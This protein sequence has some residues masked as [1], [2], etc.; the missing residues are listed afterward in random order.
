[1]SELKKCPKCKTY[2]LK[3]ECKK[4]NVQTKSTHYKFPQVR[5]APPRSVPFKR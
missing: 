1:M 2:T 5:D 3:E 4:C